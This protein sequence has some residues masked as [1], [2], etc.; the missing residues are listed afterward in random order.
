MNKEQFVILQNSPDNLK[1]R[2]DNSK[3]MSRLIA[4]QSELCRAYNLQKKQTIQQKYIDTKKRLLEN[5][6]VF[7]RYG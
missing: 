4:S 3:L 5:E 1:A 2:E 6:R 7:K